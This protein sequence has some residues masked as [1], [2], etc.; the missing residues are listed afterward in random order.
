MAIVVRDGENVSGRER[1]R[2]HSDHP[3][4][5]RTDPWINVMPRVTIIDDEPL[6]RGV[7]R[8]MLER[9]EIE[10]DEAVDGEDGLMQMRLGQPDLVFA[11]VMMPRL[12]G[13]QFLRICRRDFPDVPVV[14]MS[15]G[16][17]ADL[18]APSGALE[19]GAVLTLA[20]PF[21]RTDVERAVA[22]LLP[23]AMT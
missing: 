17:G 22:Q 5:W 11:D 16:W 20:K 10:V 1:F 7:L 23:A 8:G 21:S 3:I 12:D 13:L 15:G 14:M 6:V 18:A 2:T 19:L 9:L 4:L